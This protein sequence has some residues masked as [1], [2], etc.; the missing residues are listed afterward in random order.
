MKSKRI[1]FIIIL[2]VALLGTLFLVMQQSNP[3]TSPPVPPVSLPLNEYILAVQSYIPLADEGNTASYLEL[4]S[5]FA[6]GDWGLG[7]GLSVHTIVWFQS[8]AHEGY[9][10]SIVWYFEN[11]DESPKINHIGVGAA[12]G[13]RFTFAH[14]FYG[15]HSHLRS[16]DDFV[17][18]MVA[19][20]DEG[21]SVMPFD[22][23][24]AK[25]DFLRNYAP[26]DA[27]GIDVTY[28]EVFDQFFRWSG[29]YDNWADNIFEITMRRSL[30]GVSYSDGSHTF[31]TFHWR[32]DDY[33]V[34]ETIPS[35]MLIRYSS[36][37]H[38]T[39]D[40]EDIS[41]ILELMFLHPNRDRIPIDQWLDER[42]FL[43]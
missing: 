29:P 3:Q 16:Q 43:E 6:E 10:F 42:G 20:Y 35:F 28:A 27:Y 40:P 4:I 15:S 23:W 11:T 14:T 7:N 19:A 1:V 32:F 8:T 12:T 30:R 38:S 13:F 17:R 21:L 24:F 18:E 36:I 34:L 41:S 39:I 37:T 22:K 26:F 9:E 2:S 31:L 5:N 33:G 25:V